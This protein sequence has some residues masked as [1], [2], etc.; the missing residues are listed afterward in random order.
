MGALQAQDYWSGLASVAV[1]GPGPG[2]GPSDGLGGAEAALNAGTVVRSWPLRGTLHL[3]AVD[4]LRW[5]LE[6]FGPRTLA[7]AANREQELGIGAAEV[8][9][10][11]GVAVDEISSRGP[12]TRHELS[13]AWAHSGVDISGP[14][15]YHLMWH[16]A[17]TGL[18]CLGPVLNNQQC[19][20][21]TAGTVPPAR[22]LDREQALAEI[23]VRYFEGHGPASVRDLSRWA[24]LSAADAKVAVSLAGDGLSSL[25]VVG[26]PHFLSPGAADDLAGCRDEARGVFVLPH[27]DELIFG[28]GDKTATVPA[29]LARHIFVLA[30]GTARCTAISDGRVVATWKRSGLDA[31]GRVEVVPTGPLP[32]N[33]RAAAAALAGPLSNSNWNATTR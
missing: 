33:V 30:N 24:G 3:V 19:V 32:D 17:L 7:G 31:D 9:K 26:T 13:V 22:A 5:M 25:E 29:D 12:L 18:V 16:L 10:A 23:A 20:V 1:R 6:H 28:Y 2:S 27:F 11:G 21:L 4:D 14:R 8:E 15:A